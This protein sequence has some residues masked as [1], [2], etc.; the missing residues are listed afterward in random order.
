MKIAVPLFRN[1][2]SPRLD[3][4]DSL[5]IYDI[6]NGVIKEKKKC[7]L[8]FEH[9]AQLM[10]ILKKNEI[11]RVIC[12]GCPQF[13]LRLLYFYGIEVVGG[14]MGDPDQ[15]V[16]QSI[17]GELPDTPADGFKGRGCGHRRRHGHGVKRV[18]NAAILEEIK[19]Q[20]QK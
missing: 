7:S 2:V 9:A 18:S 6:D 11:T 15:I 20:N 17:D 19:Q 13:F 12:A 3:I 5:L 8:T 1:I 16:K 10:A 14:A 4:A